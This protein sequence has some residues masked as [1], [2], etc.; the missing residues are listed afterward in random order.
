[1]RLAGL[2]KL[3]MLDFPS[4][5]ACIV[6]TQGCNLRCSY[7]QN[8]SLIKVKGD[9]ELSEEE[10][11]NFLEKRKKQLDGVVITGGEPTIQKDLPE[12]IK[13]I[14]DLGY[15]VK[16]D[17]NGT[18]PEMIKKLISEKLV[19]YIAMDVKNILDE[20]EDVCKV[21]I[22]IGSIKKSIK[23]IKHGGIKHEF[24]MTIIKNIHNIFKIV[25]VLELIGKDEVFYLQNFED[26]EDVLDKTL[27]SFSKEELINI[28]KE[29]EERFPNVVVRGL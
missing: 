10:F 24:R 18:N 14:K 7:C 25:E 21:K 22:N 2:Q 26:S 20:Y 3:T 4:K 11:F 13:K 16:L 19:D 9:N 29:L 1:M 27:K 8:S 28:Q 12:F 17:T 6:F 5:L 15:L 23:I